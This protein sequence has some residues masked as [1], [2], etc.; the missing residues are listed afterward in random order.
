[1]RAAVILKVGS[2]GVKKAH[3]VDLP[4][5]LVKRLSQ[6][7]VELLSERDVLPREEVG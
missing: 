5:Q 4:I 3:A 1:M 2:L 6:Q 7:D